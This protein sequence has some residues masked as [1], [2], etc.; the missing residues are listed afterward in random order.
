MT[1]ISP[2]AKLCAA[3]LIAAVLLISLDPVSAGV[4]LLI[5]A[6]LLPFAGVRPARVA[7]LLSPL[8]LAAAFAGLSTLLYGRPS[9]PT[10]ATWGPWVITEGQVQLA[11]AIALRILAVAIPAIVLFASTDPTALADALAQL[12]HLPVRFVLGALVALRMLSVIADDWQQLRWA[13][14]ARG[15]GG[16]GFFARALAL[17]TLA[18][19]RGGTLATAMEARAVDAPGPRTWARQAQWRRADTLFLLGATAVVALS[20]ALSVMGGAWHVVL[21]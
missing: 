9:G 20:V 17:F 11:I 5:E 14:R 15:L 18:I 8:A 3:A 12:W 21:S 7:A 4:A 1:R 13:R 10:V 6:A 19:R 2:L 16:G